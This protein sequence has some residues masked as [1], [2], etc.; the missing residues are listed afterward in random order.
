MLGREIVR[1]RK[2][3]SHFFF[4]VF[5]FKPIVFEIIFHK[6]PAT[7][8]P[9]DPI[10]VSPYNISDALND[11]FFIAYVFVTMP[12]SGLGAALTGQYS[13]VVHPKMHDFNI[14]PNETFHSEGV[15]SEIKQLVR[16][17]VQ[18]AHA[19]P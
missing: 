2:R 14:P 8:R 4:Q 16:F 15:K 12:E 18:F 6:K 5:A 10:G 1:V 3:S 7:R 13:T 17:E 11:G 9:C 19:F